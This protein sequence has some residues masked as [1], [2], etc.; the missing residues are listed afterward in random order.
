MQ[1]AGSSPRSY[2]SI[3]LQGAGKAG[4]IKW[5]FAEEFQASHK[6]H[7]SFV[8]NLSPPALKPLQGDVKSSHSYN[9]CYDKSMRNHELVCSALERFVP[10]DH[11]YLPIGKDTGLLGRICNRTDPSQSSGRDTIDGFEMQ[12]DLR[13]VWAQGEWSDGWMENLG[14][15]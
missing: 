1:V 14:R 10:I 8:I 9:L 12:A 13:P 15:W 4:V 2:P 11:C 5:I 6:H 7:E 3:T